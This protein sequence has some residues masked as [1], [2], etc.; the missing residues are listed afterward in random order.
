MGG[1]FA[2]SKKSKSQPLKR[3]AFGFHG[4]E[5]NAVNDSIRGPFRADCGAQS[6]DRAP[7]ACS[8]G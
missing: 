5:S 4:R 2:E 7:L 6:W 3:L 8:E 1:L